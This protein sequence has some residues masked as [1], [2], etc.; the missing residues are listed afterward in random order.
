MTLPPLP[1]DWEPTRATL[2]AYAQAVGAIPRACAQAHPKWWHI[3]LKVRPTGLTTE[4]VVTLDGRTLH[5]RMDLNAHE[6]VLETSDGT[7][8]RFPMTGGVPATEMGDALIAAVAEHG[9]RGDYNRSKFESDDPRPYDPDAAAAFW[10]ALVAVHNVFARH[11]ASLDGSVGPLQVWPHGFDLAF[12]WFGT[13]TASHDEGGETAEQ[14]A[15]L[16]LGFYP[17]GRPYFYSNPWPFEADAL[18]GVDLPHGAEWHTDGWEG[19]ILHYDQLAADPEATSK[20][21]EYAAAVHEAAAP[22]LTA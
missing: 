22:T 19:S 10:R 12:E 9:V 14:E 20:L 17:G 11:R 6:V 8:R 16:N 13:R 1:E 18:L 21:A 5:L 4:P 7:S 2:H 15:Q 3:S